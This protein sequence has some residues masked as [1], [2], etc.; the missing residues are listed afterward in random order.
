MAAI[1]QTFHFCCSGPAASLAN[2]T[3][4]KYLWCSQKR[5][6]FT[7]NAVKS[8]LTEPN[9]LAGF[10]T[11]GV[12]L[13]YSVVSV[14]SASILVF[15]PLSAS[16]PHAGPADNSGEKSTQRRGSQ[17]ARTGDLKLGKTNLRP[18]AFGK[19]CVALLGITGTCCLCDARESGPIR[20]SHNICQK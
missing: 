12:R 8:W 7:L 15:L 5:R 17:D 2:Q 10:A 13:S 6:S 18:A 3:N 14:V 16:F 20:G 19:R 9:T 11:A 4:H 1:K